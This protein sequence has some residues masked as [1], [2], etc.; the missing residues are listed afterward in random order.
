MESL[1]DNLIKFLK[2]LGDNTRLEIIDLLKQ[3][4]ITSKNI[5]DSLNKSQSTISQHLKSLHDAGIIKFRRDGNQKFYSINDSNI[6]K[7]IT[8]IKSFVSKLQAEKLDKN[9]QND[10]Y[11]TLL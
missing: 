10:I 11:D 1:Y 5:Q 2:I 7:I 8:N 9:S 6:F 3:G 4:E